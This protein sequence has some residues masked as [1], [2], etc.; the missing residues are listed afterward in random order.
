MS[1]SKQLPFTP[2]QVPDDGVPR[3]RSGAVALMLGMPVATLRIWERRYRVTGPATSPTGQR[4]YSAAD[5][6]RLVLLKRLTGL[7]HAI[8]SVAGLAMDELRQVAAT[9]A[10]ALVANRLPVPAERSPWH[11][12]VVGQGLAHRLQRAE[13]Q[14]RL[15]RPLDLVGVFENVADVRAA[16]PAPGIDVLLVHL[17]GLHESALPDIAAALATLGATHAAVL[18]GFSASAVCERFAGAGIELRREPLDDEALV[19]WLR[20][21]QMAGVALPAQAPPLLE[22]L[23]PLAAEVPARRYDDAALA[24]VAGL[25]TT[26]SCECPRHVAELLMQLTQFEAYCAQCEATRPGDAALHA[27]LGRVSG[28]SRALFE[29]AL[30]YLAT[31]EGLVLPVRAPGRPPR[32]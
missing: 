31:Q 32:K 20:G 4:L 29:Q 5:V 2:M 24:D 13:V 28:T 14:H 16:G 9:H 18:Y 7:G 3:Y 8:G 25:L 15:A 10:G 30:D 26:I 11:A 22:A 21:L 23:S 17:A 6:Q 12:V 27:Y 19:D 1:D